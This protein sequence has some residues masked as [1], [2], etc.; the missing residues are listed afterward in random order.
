MDQ[1]WPYMQTIVQYSLHKYYE[2]GRM[3]HYGGVF[4]GQ[5]EY[6]CTKIVLDSHPNMVEEEHERVITGHYTDLLRQMLADI[7]EDLNK[8][9]F[10]VWHEG[11][12]NSRNKEVAKLFPELADS[13]LAIN[14]RTYDLKKIVSDGYYFDPACQGSASIKKVLPVLVP[15][16]TYEG[17]AIGRGDIAMNKLYDLIV[18]RIPQDERQQAI[19][20]LLLYCGQDTLAM[21]KI[22][23]ALRDL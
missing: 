21:V 2:D 1:T 5:G 12:E 14:D 13:F 8:S 3:Q 6:S 11:F 10:V 4:V 18:D 16:M 15:D 17:M 9:T 19:E 7:G 22:F 23:E 20:N